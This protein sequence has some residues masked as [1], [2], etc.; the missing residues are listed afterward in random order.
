[1]ENEI[2]SLKDLLTCVIAAILLIAGNKIRTLTRDLKRVS[3]EPKKLCNDCE[4]CLYY[5][6]Y[7]NMIEAE[8]IELMRLKNEQD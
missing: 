5:Q 7:N 8:K 3:A 6:T 2:L 1:M 4:K